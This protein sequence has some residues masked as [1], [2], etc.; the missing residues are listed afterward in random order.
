MN[1]DVHEP[2]MNAGAEV[3]GAGRTRSRKRLSIPSDAALPISVGPPPLAAG[4]D[5]PMR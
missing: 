1:T 2:R 3:T 4:L 5:W